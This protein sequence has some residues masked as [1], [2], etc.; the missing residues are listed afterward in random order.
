MLRRWI[1]VRG[2]SRGEREVRGRRYERECERCFQRGDRRESEGLDREEERDSRE[3][4]EKGLR[5][6][7]LPGNRRRG[8][9]ERRLG[10]ERVR[11]R[12]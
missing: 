7:L 2:K 11:G 8:E 9:K 4:I 3:G 6:E 12:E 1:S 5:G 10:A